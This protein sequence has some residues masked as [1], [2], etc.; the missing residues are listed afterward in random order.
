M[1]YLR[2]PL[3]ARIN[4]AYMITPYPFGG[5]RPTVSCGQG[6]YK[7]GD[8][9][10]H[11]WE[12]YEAKAHKTYIPNGWYT[13]IER[14]WSERKYP[15]YHHYELFI[16]EYFLGL[17]SR[18]TIDLLFYSVGSNQ[19]YGI[20]VAMNFMTKTKRK[21]HKGR[22]IFQ[23]IGYNHPYGPSWDVMSRLTR[24]SHCGVAKP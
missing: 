7:T 17:S 13:W 23:F 20:D 3:S 16:A 22:S 21:K 19:L 14:W 11:Y 10:T 1:S 15:N 2:T 24:A 18:P 6:T 8:V 5:G 4:T 9:I 12:G